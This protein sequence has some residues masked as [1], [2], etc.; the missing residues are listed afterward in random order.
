MKAE[1][2]MENAEV[3]MQKVEKSE[4][5]KQELERKSYGLGDS[6][7]RYDIAILKL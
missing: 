5:G 1:V 6:R 7:F 2:G 4:L 3:G